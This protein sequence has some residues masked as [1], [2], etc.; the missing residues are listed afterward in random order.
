VYH[1]IKI[2]KIKKIKKKEKKK[3]RKLPGNSISEK[4]TTESS[5]NGVR[6]SVI[7]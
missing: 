5:V 7:E 6:T 2:K 1:K 4:D 3:E